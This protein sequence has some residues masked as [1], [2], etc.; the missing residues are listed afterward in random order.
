[1]ACSAE[2]MLASACF[3]CR[4]STARGSGERAGGPGLERRRS[5]GGRIGADTTGM[6]TTSTL[7]SHRGCPRGR[8]K[9]LV[10]GSKCWCRGTLQQGEG[11]GY[12]G[13]IR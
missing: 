10:T 3:A 5:C 8:I 13:L 7:G 11:T 2:R 12:R 6:G 1:M 9:A 4:G